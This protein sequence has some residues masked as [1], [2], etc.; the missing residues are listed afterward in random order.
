M[1]KLQTYIYYYWTTLNA[2][3][4]AS[5]KRVINSK[6]MFVYYQE[7]K[8]FRSSENVNQ[9]FAKQNLRNTFLDLFFAGTET[10]STTLKWAVL[11]MAL[12]PEVQL[13]IQVLLL[14]GL[15]L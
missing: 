3:A 10:M 14:F 11:Y 1:D 13:K 4:K 5:N 7:K 2:V 8:I 6:V 9:K 15:F 12:Y